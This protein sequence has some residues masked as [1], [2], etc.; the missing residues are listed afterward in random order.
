MLSGCCVFMC[1]LSETA[2]H[3]TCPSLSKFP[4]V[5]VTSL[6]AAMKS[7]SCE[8]RIL[9]PRLLQ[10]VALF[11]DTVDTFISSVCLL[12]IYNLNDI[13]IHKNPYCYQLIGIWFRRFWKRMCKDLVV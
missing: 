6:I 2:E 5:I 1:I 10:I 4:D 13:I 3:V 8:A 11:P 9:F 7:G 12:F